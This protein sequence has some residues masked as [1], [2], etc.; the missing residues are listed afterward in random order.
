MP[1]PRLLRESSLEGAAAEPYRAV[2]G[3][4]LRESK[5]RREHSPASSLRTPHPPAAHPV[6]VP[7]YGRGQTSLPTPRPELCC[8]NEEGRARVMC[9]EG[10]R[11]LR[12]RAAAAGAVRTRL[13]SGQDPA[14]TAAAAPP[15]GRGA[16][17]GGAQRCRSHPSQPEDPR[18]LLPP[19]SDL[20]FPSEG[21][22]PPPLRRLTPHP[23]AVPARPRSPL[24]PY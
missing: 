13:T 10:G 6:T 5:C 4:V 12:V 24:R 20:V 3:P 17:R 21:L 8:Q 7:H 18:F 19:L 1:F 22:T 11:G 9:G 2:T 14:L 15:E 16:G 23:P